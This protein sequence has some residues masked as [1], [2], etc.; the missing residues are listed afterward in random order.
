MSLTD[1]GSD[2]IHWLEASD[3]QELP[4]RYFPAEPETRRGS[5][6]YLH[7]IQSHGAWYTETAAELARRGYSV[8]LPD[9]RGS[10]IS[11]G[12][13]GYFGPYRQLVDDVATFVELAKRE[14]HGA[15]AFVV[16][17]CWGARPAVAYALK[18]Q[19]ELAGLA[20]VCPA[21]KAQVDLSPKDKLRV[22]VG[23][24]FDEHRKVPVPL[25]PELFTRNPEY[26]DYIR[27]D[28][29]SLHEVTARFFFETAIWDRYLLRQTRLELPLLVQQAG[30]DRIIDR[31][32]VREWFGRQAAADKE[33][34][35]YPEFGHILD[36][37]NERQRYWDD[38][39][40]W[41]DRRS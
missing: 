28:A 20:L 32:T 18:S 1:A 22:G 29:L 39:A 33:Y 4:Y 36:F 41:L 37:E 35:L 40:S 15:P 17:G 13:R 26:L 25:E 9:R 27:N 38:L 19:K 24:V 11:K 23:R 3:G 12:P 14:Q 16:G 5:L 10:G 2:T 21:L 6:L 31:G 7:G 8:Y 34:V 30:D